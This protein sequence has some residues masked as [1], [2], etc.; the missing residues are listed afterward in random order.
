VS[1]AWAVRIPLAKAYSAAA[2]RL[3]PGVV[4]LESP[5]GLWLKGGQL[6]PE[7]EI[8]LRK[9]PDALL[10][11]VDESGRLARPGARI[12]SGSLPQGHWTPITNFFTPVP[13]PAALGGA[14][15]RRVPMRLVPIAGSQSPSVLIT[16]WRTWSAYAL[17]APKLRLNPLRFAL[18][19]DRR[20]LVVGLP[21]P[22]L[23]GVR[24]YSR[25]DVAVPCGW[26]FS[27]QV[28]F[29]ELR[30]LV[31]ASDGDVIVFAPDGTCEVVPRECLVNASRAAVRATDHTQSATGRT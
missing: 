24:C 13:Q 25:D 19:E 14:I 10:F 16:D 21:L 27:P 3:Q 11:D 6:S 29:T 23:P 2:L 28:D 18:C 15:D 4:V 17:E 7:L 22:P 20:V 1:G 8:L 12:P 26:G 30:T 5:E 31:G 9:L